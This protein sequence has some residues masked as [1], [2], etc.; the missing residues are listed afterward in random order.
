MKKFVYVLYA[1]LIL[2][3]TGL[4]VYDVFIAK[5]FETKDLT[6]YAILI[7]SLIA[8]IVKFSV[9]PKREIMRKKK[10]YQSAYGDFIRTAF[11]Q[12][13]KLENRL[14]Q[15]I[16]DYNKDKPAAAIEKLEKLRKQCHNSDDIY[17]VT[18]FTAL[19]YDDLH[20][21]KLAAQHYSAALNLRPHTTLASNLG[22]SRD[23]MGDQQGAIE[24]Y[25]H[26]S[27]LDPKS[28]YPYNNL[29]Q[30]YV[31]LGEYETAM[32]YAQQAI[33]LNSKMYQP[34]NAMAICHAML[35]NTA[36]YERYFRQAVSCGA[37][38]KKL[39]SYIASLDASID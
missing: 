3:T 6:K 11:A 37:D 31:R 34:L 19:C 1:L 16:D 30:L 2:A 23:R 7:I 32:E 28:A 24:A 14:Y 35:G 9:R 18:V 26:A 13:K 17:A 22:L 8:S 39:K 36:E 10:T 20:E 29:A 12:D 38:G 33:T 15:A 21:F 5:D 25:R 27:Q 4:I